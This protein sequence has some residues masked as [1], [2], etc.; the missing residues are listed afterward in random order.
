MA[1][2]LAGRSKSRHSPRGRCVQVRV[3]SGD[4][5]AGRPQ[6]LLW[7]P[8]RASRLMPGAQGGEGASRAQPGRRRPAARHPGSQAPLCGGSW[9]RS[10]QRLCLSPAVQGAGSGVGGGGRGASSC[11]VPSAEFHTQEAAKGMKIKHQPKLL[12]NKTRERRR[13]NLHRVAHGTRIPKGHVVR[14]PRAPGFE[15]IVRTK[16]YS[17]AGVGR[18]A[19]RGRDSG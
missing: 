19:L 4:A 3:A 9:L 1:G 15:L 17:S 13:L 5:R 8:G 12:I 11:L 2:L 14:C 18:E 10:C 16:A 6:G 7:G